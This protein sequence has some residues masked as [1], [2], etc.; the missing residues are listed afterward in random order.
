MIVCLSKGLLREGEKW[1]FWGSQGLIKPSCFPYLK[2]QLS[3]GVIFYVKLGPNYTKIVPCILN[4]QSFLRQF[5]ILIQYYSTWI[6]NIYQSI[7][8]IKRCIFSNCII[9]YISWGDLFCYDNAIRLLYEF[10]LYVLQD[11]LA[12]WSF[13]I[14]LHIIVD[15]TMRLVKGL[16]SESHSLGATHDSLTLSCKKYYRKPKIKCVKQTINVQEKSF[17]DKAYNKQCYYCH[18][19]ILLYYV[20]WATNLYKHDR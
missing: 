4:W 16:F 6:I 5:G 2:L 7:W 17:E 10:L 15:V 11:G 9:S 1:S 12:T 18:K 13:V 14:S 20:F 3:A 19:Y 8:R